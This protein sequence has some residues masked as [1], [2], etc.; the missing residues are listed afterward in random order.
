MLKFL[1]YNF[2]LQKDVIY[3]N[4]RIL[5]KRLPHDMLFFNYFN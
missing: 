2:T 5:S 4:P 1:S 3:H